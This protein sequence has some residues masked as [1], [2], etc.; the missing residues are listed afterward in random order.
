MYEKFEMYKLMVIML[1]LVHGKR[2][3]RAQKG[4]DTDHH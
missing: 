2:G 4:F 1:T 3:R